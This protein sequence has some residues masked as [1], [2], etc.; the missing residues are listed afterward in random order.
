MLADFGQFLSDEI[1]NAGDKFPANVD[2]LTIA[3]KSHPT[4][5]KLLGSMDKAWCLPRG[6][7]FNTVAAVCPGE[8][9]E[10]QAMLRLLS[11]LLNQDAP[12]IYEYRDAY[13]GA[14]L[15][16]G[17]NVRQLLLRASVTNESAQL[18][19]PCLNK[20]EFGSLE[21]F[22]R[23]TNYSAANFEYALRLS[24]WD[25][26][27]PERQDAEVKLQ[28]LYGQISTRT[29]LAVSMSN[30]LKT[31]F[32]AVQNWVHSRTQGANGGDGAG[33]AA[34]TD[35]K[36]SEAADR[37]KFSDSV[38]MIKTLLQ[39]TV[40]ATVYLSLSL[41]TSALA[42]QHLCLDFDAITQCLRVYNSISPLLSTLDNNYVSQLFQQRHVDLMTACLKGLE[43]GPDGVVNSLKAQEES[44]DKTDIEM[45]VIAFSL[46]TEM[47]RQTRKCFLTFPRD[48][49]G[50]AAMVY[51][52][53]AL[54]AYTSIFLL[55]LALGESDF[56]LRFGYTVFDLFSTA[57]DALVCM[58]ELIQKLSCSVMSTHTIVSMHSLVNACLLHAGRFPESSEKIY[59]VVRACRLVLWS[60]TS[61]FVLAKMYLE[62]ISVAEEKQFSAMQAIMDRNRERR[63]IKAAASAKG[64]A[65]GAG[66]AGE[67]REGEEGEEGE[68]MQ[69]PVKVARVGALR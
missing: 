60:A 13:Q 53:T 18:P 33:G 47:I 14:L 9:A 66:G 7:I 17:S 16:I 22:I 43:M 55:S 44:L 65:G 12:S 51:Y 27:I 48:L 3:A 34:S 63:V 38:R 45:R 42:V 57:Y 8:P 11:G 21:Q 24:V 49:T 52:E 41:A 5:V 20:E 35:A 62:S 59:K 68:D 29:L 46:G 32:F 64:V 37:E 36:E 2:E 15:E 28:G 54:R 26:E 30:E 6:E 31:L 61:R 19:S 10:I 39:R 67:K 40:L 69:P 23:I 4:A 56:L 25:A 1:L 58:Y 50:P